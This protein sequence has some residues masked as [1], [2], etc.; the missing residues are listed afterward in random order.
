M[1]EVAVDRL[2]AHRPARD[3]T[4]TTINLYNEAMPLDPS[5]TDLIVRLGELTAINTSASIATRIKASRAAAKTDETIN[6]LQDIVQELINDRAELQSIAT[7]LRDHLVAESLDG[8]DIRYITEKLIPT[9]EQLIDRRGG[10][11]E[12]EEVAVEPMEVAKQLV[13]TEMLTIL[14]LVGFNYKR[15]IGEPLTR[16]VEALITSQLPS[17]EQLRLQTVALEHQTE[18]LRIAQNP[19]ALANYQKLQQQ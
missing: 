1:I 16:V 9:L 4:G 12:G 11:G 7:A 17:P 18:L 10:G 14:Q 8:A 3:T 15:A 6:E 2:N 19:K 13:S 5:I